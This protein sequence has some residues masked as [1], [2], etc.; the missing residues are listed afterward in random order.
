MGFTMLRQACRRSRLHAMLE[1]GASDSD[2][3]S[4]LSSILA[5]ETGSETVN[6]ALHDLTTS[7]D[8]L[9]WEQLSDFLAA[10]PV[11]EDSHYSSILAYVSRHNKTFQSY[12]QLPALPNIPILPPNPKQLRTFKIDGRTYSDQRKHE[13]NKCY[14]VPGHARRRRS[15]RL[16][17]IQLHLAPRA[18]AADFCSRQP[19]SPPSRRRVCSD[20]VP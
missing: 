19:A 2:P 9:S 8:T 18:P 16:H 20:P 3:L 12:R 4:N 15:Y 6:S 5:A 10:A 13:G 14:P 1:D 7:A 17:T 11:L